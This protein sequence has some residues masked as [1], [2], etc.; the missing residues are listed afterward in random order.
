MYKSPLLALCLGLSL[1][2]QAAQVISGDNISI[3]YNSNGLWVNSAT[4]SGLQI[5]DDGVNFSDITFPGVA[6]QSLGVE[7]AVGATQFSYSGTVASAN[8]TTT[9]EQNLSSGSTKSASYSYTMGNLRVVRTDSWDVDGRAIRMNWT[10]SNVGGSTMSN[11]R[12]VHLMDPDVDYTVYNNAQGATSMETLNDLLDANGDGTKDWVESVGVFS[13]WTAGYGLCSTTKSTGGH[14]LNASADTDTALSDGAGAQ[15]D[16]AMHSKYVVGTM[17]PGGSASFGMVF[18]WGTSATEARRAY[19]R[20]AAEACGTCDWDGDGHQAVFCGGTDCD[21]ADPAINTAA[22]EV[23]DSVDNDCSGAVDDNA[24]DAPTWYA[25]SDGDTYGSSTVSTEQCFSAPSGYVADNTDCNDGVGTIYPNATERCNGVDDDCDGSTDEAGS[26]GETRWYRDSDGDTYGSST[27]QLACNQPTGYVSRTNDCNDSVAA[28]NPG[29]TESCNGIDDD[30]DGSTDESGSVGETTWYQD[31]DGDGYGA[32]TR[33]ACNQPSGYITTPGDCDDSLGTVN[34]A[35]T[36]AC[37][38]YDDDCD[39]AV[40]ESGAVGETT[41][42]RDDD[43]DDWG[44]TGTGILACDQPPS[45]SQRD[46]DCDDTVDSIYPGA[47]EYC[48]GVDDDCDGTVDEPDAVDAT[49]WYVDADSDSYGDPLVDLVQCY[50][51]AGYVDNDL[52]CDDSDPAL[53]PDA[54]EVYDNVD[55]DCDGLLDNVVD[56]DGDLLADQEELDVTFTDPQDPD[57]DDDGLDDGTEVNGAATNP[58]NPDSDGDGLLDGDEYIV[59]GTNP[60]DPDSDADG[61]SDGEEVLV[62][63]TDPLDPDTDED[64]AEDGREVNSSGTNPLDSDSDDDALND[65]EELDQTVTNPLDSDSDDDGLSDGLEVIDYGTDPLNPDTDA[66]SLSDGEEVGTYGTNPLDFDTDDGGIGDGTEVLQDGTDPL[67]GADDIVDPD[68]DGDGLTDST[69]LG[70]GTNPND[71][72]S[73]DDRLND[74]EEVLITLTDPL[75]ADTDD[76]GTDDGT[77]V[78]DDATDPRDYND[79]DPDADGLNNGEE[80]AVGSDPLNPDS[81]GDDLLDGEEVNTTGTDP[82]DADTDDDRLS[83]AEELRTTGTDPTDADSDDGG[84]DDGTEVLDDGTDPNAFNDDD[85]DRDGLDNGEEAGIG[86]DPI[87]PDTD[88]DQLSDG[89]EVG[90]TATDPKNPDTDGDGLSDGQEVRSY[91]TDPL[92]VDTDNGGV[93]DGEEV[94]G[95]G[96]DPLDGADDI[97]QKGWYQGGIGCSSSGADHTGAALAGLAGLSLLLR[98]RR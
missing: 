28:V 74:G 9:Q 79:D 77:E 93:G 67:V 70:L 53:N 35:G 24:V 98:R 48:N 97:S 65:G 41:W 58:N 45:Y 91:G 78:L 92:L 73:D 95:Q 40:D 64:G 32:A 66:D 27:S 22:T 37:N 61:L 52:D 15:G 21:D 42:Y 39:G 85:P 59:I 14:T 55:N 5:S 75:D 20:E 89:E 17:L 69:E 86:T 18:A 38:G 50:Q 71:P 3:N 44:Q 11:V 90:Q 82:T 1:P 94:L 68:S 54:Y 6:I 33:L 29:A 23:C 51:P 88:D 25:D 57:S 47:D 2:A 80:A 12:L 60:N 49:T 83:D 19:G 76:G 63:L 87:D 30:C 7:Y 31:S 26:V 81:D 96:T 84:I 36:E 16:L 10:L 72:D 13:G 56:S 43:K 46:G 4:S 34:P 8:F 62:Y